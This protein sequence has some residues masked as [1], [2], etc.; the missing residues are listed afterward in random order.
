M[1]QHYLGV[2]LHGKRTY[3]VLMDQNG[4]VKDRRRLLNSEIGEYVAKLPLNTWAV[5]TLLGLRTK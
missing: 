4:E 2:D 5:A 1:S 3:L